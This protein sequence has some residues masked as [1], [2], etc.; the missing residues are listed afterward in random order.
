MDLNYKLKMTIMYKCS[1][2]IWNTQRL[3]QMQYSNILTFLP[4]YPEKEVIVST[5]PY[6]K[7]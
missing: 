6:S 7:V 3:K 5:A 1:E 4:S 2:L